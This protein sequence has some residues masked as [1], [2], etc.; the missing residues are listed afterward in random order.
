MYTQHPHLVRYTDAD[1]DRE[2]GIR[3]DIEKKVDYKATVSDK[4][5]V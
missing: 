2:G 1:L 3:K 5:K 4:V